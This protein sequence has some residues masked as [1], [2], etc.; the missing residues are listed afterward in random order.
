MKILS[1]IPLKKGSPLRDLTYFTSLDIAPGHVVAVPIKSKKVLALVS[2]VSPLEQA[3]SGIKEMSFGLK[4]VS[5]DKGPSVFR[6]EFMVAA[7]ETAR[8]FAL[9][10]TALFAVLI[11]QIFLEEYDKLFK[12]K[13][14]KLLHAEKRQTG[15]RAEKLLFQYPISERISIYKTLVRESFAR[16]KSIFIVLPTEF[17]V[18]KFS[19]LLSKG[20]EQFTFTF[21]S[22]FGPK[23]NFKNFQSLVSSAHPALIL[24]TAPFLSMPLAGIGTIILEHESSNAYRT[25]K[26]PHIDLRIFA[27]IFAN[28][29]GAKFILA[30]DLLRFETI[31]R[32]DQDHLHALHP[33]SY[34]IDFSGE[35]K[36]AS[37]IRRLNNEKFRIFSQETLAEIESALGGKKNVFVFSLRKGLATATVC[38]D[39]GEMLLCGRCASPMVLYV[40]RQGEKRMFVCNRCEENYG[41]EKTCGRCGSWNLHTLGIGTDTVYEEL[42][43]YFPRV[44]IFKLDK[45]SAKTSSGAKKIFKDFEK[46]KGAILLGTEMVFFYASGKVPLSV[47]ASFDTLWSIPSFRMSEKVLNIAI[48]TA[49]FTTEKVIIE[50]KNPED[51]AVQSFR[52][53]NLLHFIRGELEDRK[54]LGYPPFVRFIKITHLGDR[55]EMQKARKFL[56]EA[57]EA[58]SP[59]IFSGFVAK[60]KGKYAT[61]ALIRMNPRDWSLPSLSVGSRIHEKLYQKLANLPPAFEVMVDPEDLL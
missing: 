56:E 60:L 5:E 27:E 47:I 41:A 9:N 3:K 15:V 21:G 6:E 1:V 28:K 53:G 51:V 19:S 52:S 13:N 49:E 57:F 2:R 33:L 44:K 54:R 22:N 18:I 50:T 59:E 45:D 14:V 38:R 46:E 48:K 8:Y 17:D 24:G 37:R 55:E 36:I 26:K 35:I 25:I 31:E 43:E 34:R 11:P 32:V 30:D 40:S 16:G 23:K 29:A 7:Q 61:N 39:C 10:E 4:K 20:I 12:I 58:Y 42:R